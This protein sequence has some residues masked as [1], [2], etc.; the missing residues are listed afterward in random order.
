M[1]MGIFYIVNADFNS[2]FAEDKDLY[3]NIKYLLISCH[4]L[5]HWSTEV[6]DESWSSDALRALLIKIL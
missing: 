6:D 3:Y 2:L 5:G 4:V 1:L